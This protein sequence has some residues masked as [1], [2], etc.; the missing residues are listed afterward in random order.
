MTVRK[1]R[2][3]T[4]MGSFPGAVMDF[5]P[6]V[7]FDL[8][9]MHSYGVRTARASVRT[10]KTGPLCHKQ[11]SWHTEIVTAVPPQ[12]GMGIAAPVKYQKRKKGRRRRRLLDLSLNS[13][14][15]LIWLNLISCAMCAL[16]TATRVVYLGHDWLNEW[17]CK[18]H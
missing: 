4:D 15:I 1:A 9:C 13:S 11:F 18:T 10:L 12:I 16:H 14:G 2:R 5:S 3:S 8:Q 17:L 7:S 6:T